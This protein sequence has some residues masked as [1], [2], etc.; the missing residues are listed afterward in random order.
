MKRKLYFVSIAAVLLG[1]ST[2]VWLSALQARQLTSAMRRPVPS[3]AE[4]ALSGVETVTF[5]ST[6]GL[7]LSGWWMPSPGS[8]TTVILLHGHGSNRRQMIGRA[9]LLRDHGYSVLLY[10]ARGHGESAGELVSFGLHEANDL[11]GALDFARSKGSRNFGLIGASQGGATI[12]L[13]GSRLRNVKWAVIESVYSDLRTAVDRRCRYHA[14]LPGWLLGCLMIPFAEDRVG[15]SIDQISPRAK[16][17]EIS[18]PVFVLSG[19]RDR[20]TMTTDTQSLFDAAK[21]PKE[22]WFVEGA[23]H[24]DLYGFAKERYEQRLFAFIASAENRRPIRRSSGKMS[25]IYRAPPL[26]CCV[27]ISTVLP[28]Q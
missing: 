9:K 10:D 17:S 14:H 1:L 26:V 16:I 3:L 15:M 19:D 28:V 5:S 2:F 25:P 11:L 13:S 24:V 6:D 20:H 12:V 7:L 23:G 21:P 27:K 8:D 18:F 22:L 4:S